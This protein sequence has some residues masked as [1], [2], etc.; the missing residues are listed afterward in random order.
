MDATAAATASREAVV[1]T[2]AGAIGPEPSAEAA[3]NL[4]TIIGYFQLNKS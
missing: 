4:I 2:A 1:T 3:G